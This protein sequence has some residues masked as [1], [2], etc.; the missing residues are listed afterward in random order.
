MTIGKKQ[1]PK[2][3][4]FHKREPYLDEQTI[5]RSKSSLPDQVLHLR[6]QKTQACARQNTFAPAARGL[7]LPLLFRRPRAAGPLRDDRVP[8]QP[9]SS[10]N[11]FLLT[12]LLLTVRS[13]L[14]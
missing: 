11:I 6:D 4:A 12:V 13:R 14:Q 9:E 7:S 5:R 3:V 10:Q 1:H 8:D 2:R